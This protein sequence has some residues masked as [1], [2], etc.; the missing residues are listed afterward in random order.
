MPLPPWLSARL[1]GNAEMVK[2]AGTMRFTVRAIVMLCT[3]AP[4]V[5]VT[6]TVAV[7][8]VAVCDADSVIVAVAPGA[9]AGLK[10]TVTPVGSPAAVKETDPAKPPVLP[11]A[12]VL[13]PLAP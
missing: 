4:P 10:A 5:P 8:T 1:V 13:L 12:I 6:V 9:G 7:P 2:S 3:I 11:I